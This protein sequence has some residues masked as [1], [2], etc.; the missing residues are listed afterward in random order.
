MHMYR[1]IGKSNVYLIFD[2]INRRDMLLLG[3]HNFSGTTPRAAQ[4]RINIPT[5]QSYRLRSLLS[6]RH[7]HWQKVGQ[8]QTHAA[9]SGKNTHFSRGRTSACAAAVPFF[10]RCKRLSKPSQEEVEGWG[11]PC[12]APCPSPAALRSK[13]WGRRASSCHGIWGCGTGTLLWSPSLQDLKYF[14]LKTFVFPSLWQTLG[15]RPS[16]SDVQSSVWKAVFL[17]NTWPRFSLDVL[18]TLVYTDRSACL[19]RGEA[20]VGLCSQRGR[21]D[22]RNTFRGVRMSDHFSQLLR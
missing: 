18:N 13:A 1:C 17:R 4:R 9:L 21:E 2:C 20:V 6:A 15:F 3:A 12:P 7:Y 22:P 11:S 16:R 14:T 8:A 10:Q 5:L 19:L